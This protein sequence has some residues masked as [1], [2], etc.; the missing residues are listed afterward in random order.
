[1]EATAETN[2]EH[3]RRLCLARVSD[4]YEQTRLAQATARLDHELAIVDHLGRVDEFL[5]VV[6]LAEFAREEGIPLRLTGM[7][8]TSW[9]RMRTSG[10]GIWTTTRESHSRATRSSQ[11][12]R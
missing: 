5:A 8:T 7:P 12:R 9:S 6:E 4:R 2:L 10:L 3:L 11:P 1:M